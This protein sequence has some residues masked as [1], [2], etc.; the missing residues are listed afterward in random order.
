ML[1]RE[2]RLPYGSEE[3]PV[4]LPAD[5][6]IQ[7]FEPNPLP[8]VGDA[9]AAIRH[10]LAHPTGTAPLRELVRQRDE[11]CILVNDFTR[12][13]KTDLFLPIIVEELNAAGIPDERIFVQF[14]NGNH[15]QQTRE[16][17]ER[18]VGPAMA[19]RLR[20]YDHDCWTLEKH[21]SYGKTSRG[22]PVLINRRVTEADRIIMT[23]EINFHILAGYSGGRKS[24]V[25]GVC[26]NDT[27]L[28]NHRMMFHEC[29]R[30]GR[31][32][33]NPIH[34]DMM[35]ACALMGPDFMLNVVLNPAGGLVKAVSGHY[36][37][38]H[39]EGCV[40]VDRMYRCPFQELADL[41]VASCGGLP[42]D[43]EFRQAHKGQENAMQALRPG[44]VLIYL[45]ECRL[46]HGSDEFYEWITTCGS[47]QE[48]REALEAKYTTGGMKAFWVARLASIAETILV[49][50]I[51]PDTVRRLRMT[52]AASVDEALDMALER[53]GKHP[54]ISVIPYAAL[55]LPSREQG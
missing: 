55:T 2:F 35:E 27:I 19:S 22:T 26:H 23:A 34:E 40:V 45:A 3:R 1:T 24:L 20:L 10:A 13:T 21:A 30:P 17:Q 15:V 39:L 37:R 9:G 33:G 25:P 54:R 28:Q 46:G 29:A 47:Q 51:D 38:G 41:V 12:M 52:P 7:V 49:S 36:A 48:I 32:E 11:V 50:E 53:V 44:G 5:D 42:M 4:R 31:L 43:V 8:A 6:V 18:I 16:M 14:A